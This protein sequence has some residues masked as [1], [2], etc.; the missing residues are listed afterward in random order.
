MRSEYQNLLVNIMEK[1]V[2]MTGDS[3]LKRLFRFL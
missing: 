3:F 2:S 1:V